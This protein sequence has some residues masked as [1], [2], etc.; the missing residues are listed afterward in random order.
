MH[1]LTWSP[2]SQ[3]LAYLSR[4]NKL[5]L[6]NLSGEPDDCPF[7]AENGLL[8]AKWFPDGNYIAIAA[9]DTAVS[10]ECCL[11]KVWLLN[12]ATFESE[13]ISNL[14]ITLESGVEQ[15]LT[16]LPDSNYLLI[17]SETDSLS[18]TLYSFRHGQ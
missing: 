17:H 12:M 11:G 2:N 18:D 16:W 8:I 15:L 14:A 10:D 9:L 1:I 6:Y 7:Q 5:C 3:R 13:V 4:D